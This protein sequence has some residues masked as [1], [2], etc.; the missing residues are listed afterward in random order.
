MLNEDDKSDDDWS[1]IINGSYKKIVIVQKHSLQA[2]IICN[3]LFPG[4]SASPYWKNVRLRR[5]NHL[6]YN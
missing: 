3:K 5:F 6:I 4:H 2:V 1:N